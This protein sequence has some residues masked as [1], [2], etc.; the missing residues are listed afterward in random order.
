VVNATIAAAAAANGLRLVDLWAVT[1][2]PWRGRFSADWFHPNDTG[3]A[4]WASAFLAAPDGAP[5]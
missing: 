1:G 2:P 3:Y 4:T 5:R